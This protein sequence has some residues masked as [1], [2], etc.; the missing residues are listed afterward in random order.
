MKIRFWL[1]WVLPLAG[2]LAVGIQSYHFWQDTRPPAPWTAEELTV[3][4][5]LQLGSLTLPQDP[6][7]HVADDPRAARMGH[8]LFFDQR[9]SING[10][11]S[12]ANCHQPQRNFTDGLQQ[13][14]AIGHLQRNTPGIVGA[15]WSPWLHWD[16]SRDSLWAQALAPLEDPLEHGGNRLFYARFIAGEPEYRQSY[17]SIFGELPDFSDTDRF[18]LH[19]GPLVNEEWNKAWQNMSVEDQH[20]VNHVFANIGKVLA[21]YQRQLIP[22]PGR[23]DDY[24]A[25]I[26]ADE[27]E[28]AESLLSADEVRGLRLFIG[29]ARCV[30]CHNGP[31]LTNNEF[32]NTGL[33]PLSGMLPDRG[34]VAVL[35][36]VRADPFN[37]L[38]AYS[39][40]RPE[41]CQELMHMRSG[42]EL[43]GAMRTP[44]LRNLAR[45]EPFMHSGQIDTLAAVLDHYNRAELA[46]IGHNETEPLGLRRR[47]LQQLE[48]FLE[49]LM[50][51]PEP[52][53]AWWQLP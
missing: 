10:L 40:A 48:R 24:L 2:L 41:Q 27:H 20:A 49:A 6:G 36:Q 21:A 26:Q 37:C 17:V 25:A 46:M 45:T 34:R 30:E 42:V 4:A 35:E 18:P 47:Q 1:A 3:L 8:Q 13:A 29:E 9:L 11:V 33:F 23:F 5:T 51:L 28:A 52:L 44:S 12:C 7:N 43:I 15:A 22:Q 38:G 31:L 19:A 53:P 50:V 16:G 32:H 14:L 39:D